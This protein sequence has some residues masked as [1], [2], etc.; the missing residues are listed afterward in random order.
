LLVRT[1]NAFHG[2]ASPPER[3]GF[4]EEAIRLVAGD[5]PDVVCLQEL[6]VWSLRHLHEWSGM[7]AVA[8]VARRPMFGP[9]PSTAEIGH[10]L[11][12]V[13]HGLFRSA[14]TGQAN[15]I[16][17]APSLTVLDHEHVVLNPWSF[18][19]RFYLG[20]AT[21][22]AWAKERRGCQVVRLKREDSTLVAANLHATS[23]H[24]E[25]LADAELLRAAT[26]VDGCAQPGEPVVLA[27][28][29]NLTMRN[30]RTL[31]E[32]TGPEW[33]FEGATTTGIDHIL[34][35]GLRAGAP[36]CW[37]VER[38]R[39]AGRVLSDHAPVDREVQ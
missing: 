37:P 24:D 23:Y 15:A 35:R 33:G 32:L 26:F 25:R 5:R 19:R 14:F 12:D 27:G 1:W 31:P 13:N 10:V 11:T 7:I 6:P 2:N 4:L 22:I 30:S 18:R 34:V 38:R 39:V 21:Q 17:L 16:L 9:F 28:D 20:V 29:F 3:R 8:D 36:G